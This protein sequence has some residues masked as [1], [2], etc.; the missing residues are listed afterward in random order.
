MRAYNAKKK[1]EG[2]GGGEISVAWYFDHLA[3]PED[4]AVIVTEAD[5]AAARRELVPSV[6]AQ[7]LAYYERVKEMF[8]GEKRGKD[9]GESKGKGLESEGWVGK[10]YVAVDGA[11]DGNGVYEGE[12]KGK[13]KA[14]AHNYKSHNGVGMGLDETSTTPEAARPATAVKSTKTDDD[15]HALN[16]DLQHA[17]DDDN[18]EEEEDVSESEGH[19]DDAQSKING[20]ESDTSD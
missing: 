2:T 17:D 20:Y 12:G 10:R 11:V 16:K 15:T 18:Q 8:E 19:F 4:T 3:T 6:S 7:E 5:F 9:G 14:L 13:G 1:S